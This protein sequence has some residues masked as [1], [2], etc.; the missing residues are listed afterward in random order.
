MLATVVSVGC[1]EC[2]DC[3]RTEDHRGAVV[4]TTVAFA[5]TRLGI[6]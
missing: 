3:Y 2:C 5:A 4:D 6:D 1:N